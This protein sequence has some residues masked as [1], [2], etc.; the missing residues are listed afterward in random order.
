[1]EGIKVSTSGKR[2]Y[3]VLSLAR[4]LKMVSFGPLRKKV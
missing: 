3:Q 4:F 2:R 1:V